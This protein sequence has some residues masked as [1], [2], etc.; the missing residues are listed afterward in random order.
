MN[1]R[2]SLI[3]T[4]AALMG[5][6]AASPGDSSA[7]QQRQRVS[8]SASGENSRFTQQYS[9]DVRDVPTHQVRIYE[10]RRAF[11]TD[12]PIVNG[13]PIKEIWTRGMADYTEDN[14]HGT[15]YSEYLLENGDR[16]FSVASFIAHRTGLDDLFANTVGYITGG[17]GTL[18]GIQG[19]LRTTATTHPKAGTLEVDTEI[20]YTMGPPDSAR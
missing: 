9:I 1:W 16:F 10:I 3:L 2:T 11:P 6:V 7:Q 17:T 8:F 12:P 15:L 20:Q 5:L 14:G 4:S 19:V 18:V 13:V